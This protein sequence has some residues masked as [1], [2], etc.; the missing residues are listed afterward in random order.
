MMDK[1][2]AFLVK[3]WNDQQLQR[4]KVASAPSSALGPELTLLEKRAYLNAAVGAST[5][6]GYLAQFEGTPLAPQA[7]ALMEQELAM[8]SRH[9]Q[10][11]MQRQA[12]DALM[13]H[14]KEWN[15]CEALD[16]QKKQLLLELAK[17]KAMGS[18][19]PTPPGQAEIGTPDPA[20]AA[21]AAPAGPEAVAAPPGAEGPE[22]MANL[23][24][25]VN[26][27]AAKMTAH[28]L[29]AALRLQTKTRGAQ[30][31]ASAL[32][33][34]PAPAGNPFGVIAKKPSIIPPPAWLGATK[35]AALA[36]VRMMKSRSKSC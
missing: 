17:M 19:M 11:R 6:E 32:G 35:A 9:L 36:H 20:L 25:I 7:I 15:E 1:L 21:P 33:H 28:E 22:K 30:Q 16:L 18:G 12:Q 10:Q 27:A 13:D 23:A 2:S 8:K 4:N 26:P 34:A 3:N 29:G 31:L 24:T 5:D 14:S